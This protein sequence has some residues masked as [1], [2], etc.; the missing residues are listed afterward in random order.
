[1]ENTN[2]VKNFLLADDHK[3]ITQSLAFM[4]KDLYQGVEVYQI[5][6]LSGILKTLKEKGYDMLI[7]DISF[8]DG[9]TLQILHTIRKLY[10]LLKILI[11]SGHDEELYAPRYLNAGANG[12]VSK[13]ASES[14]IK[15]AIKSVVA[16]GIYISSFVQEKLTNSYLNRQPMNVLE[17][18]STRELEIANLLSQG[19]SNMEICNTLSLQRSTV[20]T[21][22]NRIFEKLEINN[23]AD[24]FHLFKLYNNS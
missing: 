12:F 2:S 3:I 20:S 1:M 10:P 23:I 19:Y 22:K 4:I 15:M 21:Y 16:S 18:L 24:L 14:D 8:P 11:F 9:N 13:L 7:L 6:S 17:Q 5:N